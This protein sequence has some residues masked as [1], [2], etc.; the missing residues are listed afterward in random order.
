MNKQPQ[1]IYINLPVL[2]LAKSKKF[3]TSIGFTQNDQFS[4]ETSSCMVLSETIMVMLLTA[5]SP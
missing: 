3:Y 2:D 5:V 4:D 1:M